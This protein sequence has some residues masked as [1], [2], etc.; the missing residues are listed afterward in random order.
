[1]K[2]R[3]RKAAAPRGE[4]GRVSV[5][6]DQE[7]RPI[8]FGF[9]VDANDATSVLRAIQAATLTWGGRLCP[10]IP[11]LKRR[12][13]WDI[14]RSIAPDDL[15]RGMLEA[16]EPDVLVTND[17]AESARF[18][19]RD[20]RVLPIEA[21]FKEQLAERA[22]LAMYFVYEALYE[23]EFRYHQRHPRHLVAAT[24]APEVPALL[25][26]AM[27]GSVPDDEGTHRAAFRDLGAKDEI[28]GPR[29]MLTALK[30]K[31][32]PLRLTTDF[33]SYRDDP[34]TIILVLD[35]RRTIDIIDYWNLRALGRRVVPLPAA[36]IDHVGPAVR[37]AIEQEN[38]P[39]KMLQPWV[40]RASFVRS[41]NVDAGT[42]DRV[43]ECVAA[44]TTHVVRQTW[45]P[46][47]FPAWARDSD[48]TDRREPA[49]TKSSTS[50]STHEQI[51]V[52][53]SLPDWLQVHWHSQP[54][55]AV[56]IR[57]SAHGA[58]GL[59]H[60]LP[61]GV[62]DVG[63]LFGAIPYPGATW[64]TVHGLVRLVGDLTDGFSFTVPTADEAMV[65]WFGGRGL[66][67]RPSGAGRI[68]RQMQRML[69]TSFDAASVLRAPI[70]EA[71]AKAARSPTRAITE[72]ALKEALQRVHSTDKERAARHRQHLL[73]RDVLR[74]GI[75]TSCPHCGQENWYPFD[76]LAHTVECERCVSAFEFP[77]SQPP[78]EDSWG[79]RLRGPFAIEGAGQGA[80]GV[81][82]AFAS[83]SRQSVLDELTWTAGLD[84][85]DAAGT[86]HEVDFVLCGRERWVFDPKS[87]PVVAV[88]E[89]KTG[90]AFG[91][92]G[93]TGE[94]SRFGVADM[95]RA[96]ALADLLPDVG[97]V[98]ATL[99]DRL[100]NAE[101][102]RLAAF[103]RRQRRLRRDPVM[104]LTGRELL[105]N[106]DMFWTWS[107]SAAGTPEHVL[108]EKLGHA[109]SFRSV[110]EATAH[111]YLDVAPSTEWPAFRSTQVLPRRGRRS[112]AARVL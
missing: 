22:G 100:D 37:A 34:A 3:C 84:L 92:K 83:L 35:P 109:R 70:I 77:V 87:A 45:M 66:K 19:Y 102:R 56:S 71:F 15:M 39:Q 78:R 31:F 6:I 58:P 94:R 25:H 41:R 4:R 27:F 29:T 17:A 65:E 90:G 101:R 47:F 13:T 10:L 54:R 69:P 8:R 97:F 14:G 85:E 55:F 111:L 11:R 68:A 24:G 38:A 74:P 21:L 104:V 49:A 46:R 108:A 107:R 57:I 53:A 12:R 93:G 5:R 72:P 62:P 64:S 48:H 32:S 43:V 16:F 50:F 73:D 63:R 23:Q 18:G 103:V 80:Y 44:P 7:L 2:A 86:C 75:R 106:D 36:W 40:T 52:E 20:Q 88:G 67:A 28:V 81:L 26:A 9:V 98:F 1:M 59:V 112:A 82:A 33:L 30:Q 91:V 76:A 79:F 105:S 51:R 96:R 42:F 61:A 95:R 60:T 110:A 89:A 99:A